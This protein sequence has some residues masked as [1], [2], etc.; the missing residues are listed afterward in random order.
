MT[1]TSSPRPLSPNVAS[2]PPRHM[3]GQGPPSPTPSTQDAR[4][5][6]AGTPEGRAPG[7]AAQFD[8]TSL[9]DLVQFECLRRSQ[10]I[11]R[12]TSRGQVGFLYFRGGQI[13]HA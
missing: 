6:A 12:I 2:P 1:D 11:L 9:W 3:P 5:D 13:V 4:Q 7:F 8:H 10:R